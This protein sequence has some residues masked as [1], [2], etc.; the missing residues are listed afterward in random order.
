MCPRRVDL[1]QNFCDNLK[2][3]QSDQT[4]RLGVL[5]ASS[6]P[7]VYLKIIAEGPLMS[8]RSA[9]LLHFNKLADD[10]LVQWQLGSS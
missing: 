7:K 4:G 10:F 6:I 8:D 1:H 9:A 3:R 2:S 5:G